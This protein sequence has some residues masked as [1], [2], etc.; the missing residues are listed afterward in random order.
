MFMNY[1][2]TALAV[3]FKINQIKS[4]D[5]FTTPFNAA[6]LQFFH[7]GM[8]FLWNIYHLITYYGKSEQM[9]KTIFREFK[10]IFAKCSD[11]VRNILKKL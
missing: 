3:Y 4:L 5:P 1:S 11:E 8:M 6:L 2:P 10:E 9:R 7:H